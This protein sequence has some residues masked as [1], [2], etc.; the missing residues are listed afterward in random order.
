MR[1]THP[2]LRCPERVFNGS[3]A[4]LHNLRRVVQ[5]QLHVLQY[6][7]IVPAPDLFFPEVGDGLVIRRQTTGKPSQFVVALRLPFGAL[8]GLDRVEIAI[9]VDIHQ[10]RM[11]SRSAISTGTALLI[12][13]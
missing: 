9:D 6:R 5:A 12:P 4:D 8:A 2:L 13:R 7:L 10:C 1:C 3:L 11:K